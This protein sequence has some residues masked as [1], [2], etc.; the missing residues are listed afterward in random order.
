MQGDPSGVACTQTQWLASPTS[1]PQAWGVGD[2]QR[3]QF[4]SGG[5][6]GRGLAQGAASGG[7]VGDDHCGPLCLMG[8]RA[9]QARREESATGT[10]RPNG[11]VR[12]R[13]EPARRHQTKGPKTLRVPVEPPG[14]A[15]ARGRDTK[16]NAGIAAGPS[17]V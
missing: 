10:G 3:L 6:L 17:R 13:R 2:W 4:G 9:R 11:I 7:G 5:G 12:A 1:M 15:S 16:G 8:V 14:R